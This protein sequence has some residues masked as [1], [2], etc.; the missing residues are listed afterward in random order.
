QLQRNG[1][2]VAQTGDRRCRWLAARYANRR[3]RSFL[4][5]A[6]QRMEVQ[7]PA[8]RG[9]SGR[10]SHRDDGVQ[11]AA[12]ALGQGIDSDGK[13]D[14][15]ERDAFRSP[16]SD[17]AGSLVSPDRQHQLSVH[18]RPVDLAAAG[19]DHP[20]LPGMVPDAADRCAAIHGLDVFYLVVLSGFAEG[21]VSKA[22]AQDFSVSSVSD[23]FGHRVD[24]N[25]PASSFR[26][27]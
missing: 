17:Q 12:G 22:L 10:A 25:E 24:G 26:S 1:G 16:I 6:A 21:I 27:L 8:G 20:L 3:Y 15:P 13:E 11:N 4:S 5:L 7:V 18:G 23:S 14:P 9:V 19:D 2:D